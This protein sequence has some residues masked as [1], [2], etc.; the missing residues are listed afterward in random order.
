MAPARKALPLVSSGTMRILLSGSAGVRL[1]AAER[2][3]A[4]TG[5]ARAAPLPI[6]PTKTA[7]AR[8]A[9]TRPLNSRPSFGGSYYL[10]P[11][12]AREAISVTPRP[13]VASRIVLSAST[14]K[15]GPDL[16]P[17][18]ISGELAFSQRWRRLAGEPGRPTFARSSAQPG[19]SGIGL[20]ARRQRR[21]GQAD[22]SRGRPR[23]DQP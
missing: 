22:G 7:A 10:R 18:A 3:A 11:V 19:G 6:V 5:S 16:G 4:A 8:A 14:S 21:P 23:F 13:N 17:F 12:N 9:R 15:N 2:V 20:S 1:G